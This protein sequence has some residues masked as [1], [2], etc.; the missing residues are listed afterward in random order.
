MNP[1]SWD[2]GVVYPPHVANITG[3][4]KSDGFG[5]ACYMSMYALIVTVVAVV[6]I[7]L[8]TKPKPDEELKN[9]VMGLT[10]RVKVEGNLFQRPI[11]WAG[12]VSVILIALNIY[13]W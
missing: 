10:P 11:F 2:P 6:A 1:T 8:V 7:S 12:V 9:L 3:Y 13:F 4:D 5:Q